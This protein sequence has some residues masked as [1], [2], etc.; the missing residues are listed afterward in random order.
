MVKE[1]GFILAV[2]K[3]IFFGILPIGISVFLFSNI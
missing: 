1:E 3:M 2:V